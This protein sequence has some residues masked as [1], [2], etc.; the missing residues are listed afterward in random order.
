MNIKKT[1]SLLGL[2]LLSC[3]LLFAQPTKSCDIEIGF[4]K[5]SNNEVFPFGDTAKFVLYFLN[6]GPDTVTTND[7]IFFSFSG[8]E[9]TLPNQEIAPGD[10]AKLQVAEG[11]SDGLENDT[12]TYWAKL[13]PYATTYLQTNEQNDSTTVTFIMLGDNSEGV[14][15]LKERNYQIRIY[16]N[17]VKN[18]L[19]ISEKDDVEGTFLK[20][21][22]ISIYNASG[23]LALK[24]DLPGLK[25]EYSLNLSKLASG[26]YF[27]IIKSKNFE[28]SYHFIKE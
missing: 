12:I 22:T 18:V 14:L 11:Y 17:P 16:P 4:D 20:S 5:P 13:L 25:K 9:A 27:I 24:K 2:M 6:N 28:V 3:S 21:S 15:S 19:F 26:N 10:T 1:F 7:T 23:M 8:I